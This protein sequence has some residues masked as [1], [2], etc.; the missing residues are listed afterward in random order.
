MSTRDKGLFP[1]FIEYI[2]NLSASYRVA[3]R[4]YEAKMLYN[5]KYFVCQRCRVTPERD[6]QAF[7][8]RYD[9]H[10]DWTRYRYA[11]IIDTS[12]FSICK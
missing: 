9:Q 10:L 12:S 1:R 3:M 6:F 4:I 7:C 8:E 5:G 11:K 2:T